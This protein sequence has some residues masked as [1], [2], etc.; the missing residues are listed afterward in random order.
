MTTS[1]IKE[2][3]DEE[4]IGELEHYCFAMGIADTHGNNED[5]DAWMELTEEFKQELL[6]RLKAK[7]D[8]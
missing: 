3:S 8:E 2:L 5:H 6:N 4:L 7:R 1:K